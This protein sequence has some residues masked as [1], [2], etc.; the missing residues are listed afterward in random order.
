[1]NYLFF[2]K[3]LELKALYELR[4]DLLDFKLD[5]FK[6]FL[7]RTSPKLLSTPED[8]TPQF[9]DLENNGVLLDWRGW[10]L[11]PCFLRADDLPDVS[12]LISEACVGF[13][14]NDWGAATESLLDALDGTDD[15][16]ALHS[17]I[18][19]Q[20]GTLAAASGDWQKARDC[21][22]EGLKAA[23]AQ[24]DALEVAIALHNLGIAQKMTELPEEGEQ[25]L[26]QSVQL[27]D[28]I[29]D[30]LGAA[31]TYGQFGYYWQDTGT[32]EWV[33]TTLRDSGIPQASITQ[34]WLDALYAQ[35]AGEGG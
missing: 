32:L 21:F 2:G 31:L 34:A 6:M 4:S 5:A 18:V 19:Q 14:S 26:W 12:A 33:T 20:L 23:R 3:R 10:R 30:W 17:R 16:P 11:G 1:M 22:E 7:S 15:N 28:Q 29:E 24:N 8:F 25:N 9:G 27:S 35:Q 13:A